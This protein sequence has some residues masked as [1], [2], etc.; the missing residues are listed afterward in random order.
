M[1][2]EH[3]HQVGGY[4]DHIQFIDAPADLPSDER[5]QQSKGVP[6][7]SLRASGQIPL[8]DQVFEKEAADPGTESSC[9]QSWLTSPKTY[10]AKRL[11][12]SCN[13]SGVI[14]R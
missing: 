5:N 13:S 8:I 6:V 14:V 7:A 3:P 10:L 1:K 4:V 12:A 9:C 11:L 2:K